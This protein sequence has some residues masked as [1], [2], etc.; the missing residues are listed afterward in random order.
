MP[1]TTAAQWRPVLEAVEADTALCR[2]LILAV[3]YGKSV[4]KYLDEE[5]VAY[6]QQLTPI[7]L[8]ALRQVFLQTATAARDAL[9]AALA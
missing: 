6:E 5:G 1:Y 3:E 8:N 4:P 2:K 7:Q 9:N